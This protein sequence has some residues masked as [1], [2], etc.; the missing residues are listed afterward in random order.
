[1]R[2]PLALFLIFIGILLESQKNTKDTC[3]SWVIDTIYC[4]DWKNFDTIISIYNK[5]ED[6]KDKY[7][8]SIWIY[9]PWEVAY[10]DNTKMCNCGCGFPH[11]WRQKKISKITGIIQDRYKIQSYKYVRNV[12]K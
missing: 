1:M 11:K 10:Q 8:Y 12:Q 5:R 7:K 2:L 6:N 3:G 9:T 4:S